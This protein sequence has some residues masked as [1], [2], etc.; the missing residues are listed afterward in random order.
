MTVQLCNVWQAHCDQLRAQV[1]ASQSQA[2]PRAPDASLR[3][4]EP[5]QAA[6]EEDSSSSSDSGE[7]EGTAAVVRR[8][9]ASL[10][11]SSIRDGVDRLR[12]L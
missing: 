9:R 2:Q 8:T 3:V 1:V 6:D 11:E 7:E 5:S 4:V 10:R 12:C